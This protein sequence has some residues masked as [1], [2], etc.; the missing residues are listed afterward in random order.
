MESYEREIFGDKDLVDEFLRAV[1]L[2]A[3]ATRYVDDFSKVTGGDG[4]PKELTDKQ[5][6]KRRT[7][8]KQAKKARRRNRKK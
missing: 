3:A 6:N 7:K 5:R 1:E 2:S 4:G 8:N